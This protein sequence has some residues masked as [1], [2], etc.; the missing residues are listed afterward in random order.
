MKKI[1]FCAVAALIAFS[2]GPKKNT[3]TGTIA[4]LDGMVYLNY[5]EGKTPVAKDSVMVE[6]GA[7]VFENKGD[8]QGLV[9]ITKAGDKKP[10]AQFFIDGTALPEITVTGDLNTP[11][12]IVIAGSPVNDAYLAFMATE[13]SGEKEN[14]LKF[15]GE[16]PG[17]VAAAYLIYRKMAPSSTAEELKSYVAMLTPEVQNCS[18]IKT[19]N[20]YIATM[21]RVAVGQPFID[22]ALPT[23]AGDTVALSS[24]LAQGNYVLLDFWASWCSPCRH[25]NPNVVAAFQKYNKKGFTVYGVSLDMPGDTA[26]WVQAIQDDKLTWTNVSDIQG[27]ECAPA[28][29]YAVRSIPAN[30]LIAPDGTIVAT[31]LRGEELMAKLEELL[32]KKK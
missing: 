15:V 10:I 32:G 12:A 28:K 14:M 5:Q 23:P 11:E 1:L 25:E 17:S 21:E 31:K 30:F 27:W 13:G 6:N 18:Y 19:L 3:I 26:K 2:C 16:N 22:I 9:S 4:N 8:F 29:Q 24:I 7:F 20:E